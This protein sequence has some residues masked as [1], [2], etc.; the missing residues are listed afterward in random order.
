[1]DVSSSCYDRRGTGLKF[2]AL[3][4]P[5]PNDEYICEGTIA[6][7]FYQQWRIS[8]TEQGSKSFC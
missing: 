8:A 2:C 3:R 7:S 6:L 5:D 1:M 4:Q